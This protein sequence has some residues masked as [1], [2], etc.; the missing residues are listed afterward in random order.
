MHDETCFCGEAKADDILSPLHLKSGIEE[1]TEVC[2]D[3]NH[4]SLALLSSASYNQDLLPKTTTT[5]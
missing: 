4:Y 5:F 2:L 3:F 1:G